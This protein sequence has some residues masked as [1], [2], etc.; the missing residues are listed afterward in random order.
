MKNKKVFI[1]VLI[2]MIVFFIFYYIFVFL[3]NNK[4]INQD[5]IVDKILNSFIKYEANIIVHV[6]SNKNES[7]Y[8]MFQSVNNNDSKI[9]VSNPEDINGL[10][11]EKNNNY[12]KISNPKINMER[13][14]SDYN[15]ALNNSLFLDTFVKDFKN[16]DSKVLE[17]KDKIIFKV[18]INDNFNTYAN[19]KELYVNKKT[20]IPEKLLIKDN[21]QKIRISII[22]NDIKIK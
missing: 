22:Y 6:V 13:I 17:E 12:L 15:M 2:C 5:E 3:G 10:T 14:Y 9:V 21:T 20:G 11:I 19:Y 8:S 1:F 18:K 7:Y 4:N 16:N